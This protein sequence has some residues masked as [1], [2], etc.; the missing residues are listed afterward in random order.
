MINIKKINLVAMAT[1][2]IV[3]FGTLSG[4]NIA[5]ISIVIGIVFF[6]SI[7]ALEKNSS[8]FDGLELK[9]IGRSLKNK[10]IL[11][12]L[13]LPLFMNVVSIFLATLILPEFIEHL[14]RRTDLVVSF[15]RVI[16]LLFQ[17]A[18]L[19]VGEEIAWRAFF[20][21]QLNK[22]LQIVPTIIVTSIIFA[23]GHMTNGNIDII[24]YDIFLIFI[25]SVLYGVIFYKTKNAW[26]SAISHYTA[27][28]FAVFVIPFML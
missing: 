16:L 4:F 14:Y 18:L 28:L 10:T 15:D 21:N 9:N 22:H 27:N 25:N 20:Q 26:I 5:G 7:K 12:W 13:T 8:D 23:F 17:L 2:T 19:A 24:V 3:S 11:M 1:M 6:F